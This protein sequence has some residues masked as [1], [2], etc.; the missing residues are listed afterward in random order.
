MEAEFVARF[1]RFRPRFVALAS[2]FFCV[3]VCGCVCA[4]VCFLLGC[5]GGG[6]GPPGY[7]MIGTRGY[8]Y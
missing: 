4:R 1:G 7:K 5:G 3:C 6:G 8:G 2:F